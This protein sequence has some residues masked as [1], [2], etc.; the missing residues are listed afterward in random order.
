M[1][2]GHIS[3]SQ[4]GNPP[5]P[6]KS[7]ADVHPAC[8]A[9]IQTQVTG[10][11]LGARH[12]RISSHSASHSP[13]HASQQYPV[14]SLPAGGV[15][16]PPHYQPPSHYPPPTVPTRH[17]SILNRSAS[18]PYKAYAFTNSATLSNYTGSAQTNSSTNAT[19]TGEDDLSSP[20]P[21]EASTDSRA[22]VVSG[23]S[24]R[25]TKHHPSFNRRSVSF[26]IS[27]S[28][29]SSHASGPPS[30]S[31]HPRAA[32]HIRATP[33]HSP[34]R[35]SV[36]DGGPYDPR[37]PIST[38]GLGQPQD[39]NIRLLQAHG[40]LPRSPTLSL[41]TSGQA[42]T[43]YALPPLYPV[44]A[45][46]QQQSQQQQPANT[47][48]SAALLKLSEV[49]FTASSSKASATGGSAR[50]GAS[51][52]GNSLSP[53]GSKSTAELV[54][55]AWGRS[56]TLEADA[57]RPR[58]STFYALGGSAS[59]SSMQAGLLDEMLSRPNGA[60][61]AQ[62]PPPQDRDSSSR[63]LQKLASHFDSDVED[64]EE[65][66]D[67]DDGEVGIEFKYDVGFSM[68]SYGGGAARREAQAVAA[69]LPG[70]RVAGGRA[71]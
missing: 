24:S 2:A 4:S 3:A 55:L 39:G 41:H 64:D 54:K 60:A 57:S 36:A 50:G 62:P 31:T 1:H 11:Q 66:S 32:G 35:G 21:L 61:A 20:P 49:C 68:D 17:P 30:P 56:S 65:N 59:G 9:I 42:T 23:Q 44:P 47:S 19:T 16:S 18:I 53:A 34:P 48:V 43:A 58:G 14:Q 28:L 27:K 10:I 38:R 26:S 29:T 45:G 69:N 25:D 13:S 70:R 37:D 7:V 46:P 6:S 63:I 52:S 40:G 67:G 33:P 12:P 8:H 51:T 15:G 71:E 22:G 5:T